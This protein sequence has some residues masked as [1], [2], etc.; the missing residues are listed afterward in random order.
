MS[1]LSH[2]QRQHQHQPT[3]L[4]DP[5]QQEQQRPAI[6]YADSCPQA[7]SIAYPYLRLRVLLLVSVPGTRVRSQVARGWLCGR[8]ST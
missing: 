6:H 7:P 3:S 8:A 1:P 4:T 5:S 2:Y